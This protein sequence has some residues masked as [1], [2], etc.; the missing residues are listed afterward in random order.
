MEGIGV[1]VWLDEMGS[2]VADCVWDY[3]LGVYP[4]L[5]PP[6]PWWYH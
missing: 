2:S 5:G 3:Y 1:L 4:P 6:S